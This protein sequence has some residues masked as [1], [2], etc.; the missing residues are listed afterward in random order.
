MTDKRTRSF[1]L[2]PLD[3]MLSSATAEQGGIQDRSPAFQPD[4]SR[5]VGSRSRSD[6]IFL[7]EIQRQRKGRRHRA[8][9]LKGAFGQRCSSS[10]SFHCSSRSSQATIISSTTLRAWITARWLVTHLSF[11]HRILPPFS[12]VPFLPAQTPHYPPTSNS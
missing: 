3:R 9:T 12:H 8:K 10:V 11:L 2:V 5:T 4:R 6:D 1:P 7:A